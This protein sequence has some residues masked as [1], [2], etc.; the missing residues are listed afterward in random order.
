M[1]KLLLFAVVLLSGCA[2]DLTQYPLYNVAEPDEKARL[3]IDNND[4]KYVKPALREY[5]IPSSKQDADFILK[6]E[7]EDTKDGNGGFCLLSLATLFIVPCW[8]TPEITYSYSLTDVATEK[9]VQLS[10]VHTKIREYF[11]WL[12]I[13]ML[14]SSDVKKAS[15]KR[16][17][18]K[19]ASIAIREAA[20]LIYNPNSRLYKKERKKAVPVAPAVKKTPVP[21]PAAPVQQKPVGQEDLDMLW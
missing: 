5:F 15:V 1:K 19:A 16:Y 9:V 17:Q 13:P 11:G 4:E 7:K 20:S 8:H 10:D 6:F 21:T 18:A 14:I 2:K 3:Y 12:L